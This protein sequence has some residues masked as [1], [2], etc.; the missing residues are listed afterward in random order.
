VLSSGD[1]VMT[2]AFDR[3]L[4]FGSLPAITSTAENLGIPNGFLVRYTA[5]GAPVWSSQFGGADFSVG[6]GLTALGGDDFLLSGSVA[7]DLELGGVSLPGEPFTPTELEPFGPTAAFVARLSGSGVA[8][9][10]TLEKPETYGQLVETN[11]GT[12]FLGGDVQ[13]S[14]A[15][16]G[17][18]Y[19]RTYDT[20]DGTSVQLVEA[21]GG[22][23]IESAS[24]A[25]GPGVVWV[26]GRFTGSADFG[27]ANALT[28][29]A[30]VFL[31]RLRAGP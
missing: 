18:A 21:P 31:L 26:A 28:A 23:S 7:L 9:W 14:D 17:I 27:N 12:V 2:G 10:V 13:P 30:G 25:V 6:T 3:D 11:G 24:L 29:N 19:L 8:D 15:M 4:T 1:V 16:G 5:D 20:T 22:E